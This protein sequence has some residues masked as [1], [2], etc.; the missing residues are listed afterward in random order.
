MTKRVAASQSGKFAALSLM[1]ALLGGCV[2]TGEN[3]ARISNF[4]AAQ[5][6]VQLGVAYMQQGHLLLAKDKLDRAE[7]QNPRNIEGQMALAYL[8]ERLN[9]PKVAE[10]YYRNAQ[11]LAP[12]NAEVANNYAV[13]LCK[14]ERVDAALTLFDTASKDPLYRTPWAALTNA[15]V[16]LRAAKRGPEA[17]AF[18]VRALGL[19]PNYAEGVLALAEVQLEL[20]RAD[21]ATNAID[22]F[23]TMG[24][25]TPDIL[26]VG[27]RSAI[28]RGDRIAEENLS[29]RLRRDFPN[30]SQARSLTQLQRN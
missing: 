23:L 8:H 7:K 20:G 5:A 14:A 1:L 25:A 27:V 4:D 26:L 2:T 9:Q 29:R 18:L 11:R 30:S 6:N 13:F 15:A 16:C 21:L 12:G 3:G 19:R 22:R 24:M 17:V 28:A 10:R